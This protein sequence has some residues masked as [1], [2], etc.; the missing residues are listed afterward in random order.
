MMTDTP[1]GAYPYAG[2]PWFSTP[3]GRDGIITAFEMLW[4]NPDVARGVLSFLAETQAD[5]GRRCAR[6]AAGKDPARDAR[7]GDGGARRGAVRPL[8]R[9]LRRR[10][11][12]SSCSPTRTT[13]R[14]GDLALHRS[15]LAEHL[16]RARVDAG[17]RRS[18]MATASSST[19]GSRETGLVQQGWKDSHDSV[20]HADGSLAEPPIALCEV[21]G[22]AYAAWKGAAQLALVRGDTASCRRVDGARRAAARAV[23]ARL[24]VRGA[25]HL[26]AGARWTTSGRA[27]CARPTPGTACLRG[28][29]RPSAPSASAPR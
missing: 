28:S 8:L 29:S 27:G 9:Q 22:Y 12:S 20:F 4:L 18:S 7:R 14:T 10:R 24:L 11:R 3:F 26:R 2:I 25:R 21:Q 6:R 17:E 19:R 5:D 13:E 1:H 16:A 15:D 23:R